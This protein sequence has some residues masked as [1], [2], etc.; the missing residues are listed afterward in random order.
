MIRQTAAAK[1]NLYL[2]VVGKRTDGYHL[3]D[4]L[5]AFAQDGDVVTVRTADSLSLEIGGRYAKNLTV[6]ENNSVVKAARLLAEKLNVQPKASLFLQKNMP[7]ASG[8]G[9]GSAD[10]AAALLALNKLWGNAADFKTLCEIAQK[11]GAD[12][13]ACLFSQAVFVS[14][15]GEQ[16]E[17]SPAVP[18]LPVLLVNP[19]IALSTPA[20]FKNRSGAFSVADK[21]NTVD[22]SK[23]NFIPALSLRQN[24][25]TVSA[26]GLVPEIQTVLDALQTCDSCLLARMSGSGAT[27]FALFKDE[28]SLKTAEIQIKQRYPD[29]WVFSSFLV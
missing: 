29:W 23:E 12:V 7:V 22:F 4:S 25:L 11:I 3:L 13:P 5:F 2:H 26:I 15:I 27:C 21:M 17:K 16:I 14:G 19:N 18:S 24:D 10:A 1:I 9:G 8:I 28:Q 20:V 6:D